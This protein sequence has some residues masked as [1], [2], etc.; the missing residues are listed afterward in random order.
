MGSGR[1]VMAAPELAMA[2]PVSAEWRGAGTGNGVTAGVALGTS[3]APDYI[4][5]DLKDGARTDPR[6]GC[7][8]LSPDRFYV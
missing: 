1:Q 6:Y 4:T 8:A 2:A 3:D 7:E 5:F